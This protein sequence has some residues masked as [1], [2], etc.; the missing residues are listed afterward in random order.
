ME[1]MEEASKPDILYVTP[2]QDMLEEAAAEI[3]VIS[4]SKSAAPRQARTYSGDSD[5][6]VQ[7]GI[8]KVRPTV[9]SAAAGKI[10]KVEPLLLHSTT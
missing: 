10:Q 2:F 7:Q 5:S 3:S 1:E 9:V 6:L 4:S 8:K